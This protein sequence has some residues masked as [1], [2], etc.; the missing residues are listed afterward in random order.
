[1]QDLNTSKRQ[2]AMQ[3]SPCTVD[4]IDTP[5]IMPNP[6]AKKS[7]KPKQC[8]NSDDLSPYLR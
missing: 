3:P 6:A 8:D 1:M 4:T 2:F 5:A 7:N